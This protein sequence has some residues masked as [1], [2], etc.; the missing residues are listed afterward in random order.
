[1]LK[2]IHASVVRSTRQ[3]ETSQSWRKEWH[4]SL[5]LCTRV[6]WKNYKDTTEQLGPLCSW[7]WGYHGCHCFRLCCYSDFCRRNGCPSLNRLSPLS[8]STILPYASQGL[9]RV[10]LRN[11][12]ERSQSMISNNIIQDCQ[13]PDMGR[14][15]S[16][17]LESIQLRRP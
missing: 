7:D 4:S 17:Q 9:W 6:C 12:V 8:D 14:M 11:E 1:M 5:L 3:K 15:Y 2:T 13:N 16:S 10:K